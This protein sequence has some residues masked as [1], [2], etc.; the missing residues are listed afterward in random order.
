MTFPNPS[1]AL[2][3]AV[4]DELIRNGV[5]FAVGSPGSRSTALIVELDRRSE[6]RLVMQLDERSGSFRALGNSVATE[7]PSVVV[8]T[9]GSAVANLAP[10]IAEAER[11]GV[12]LIALTADRPKGAIERRSNQ[13]MDHFALFDELVRARASLGP[14][15]V[16]DDENA[17]WR[18][19]VAELVQAAKG[20]IQPPGPVHL[21]VAFEE[22]TVPVPDDGRSRSPI[23]PFTCEGA[24]ASQPWI[25]R[26]APPPSIGAGSIAANRAVVVAGR[27]DYDIEALLR[28]AGARG[29]P[30]L[31][32]AMSGGRGLDGALVGYAHWLIDGF[33][34]ALIP[35]TVVIAGQVNPGDRIHQ[36]TAGISTVFHVDRF[37]VFSDPGDNMSVGVTGDPV[38]FLGGFDSQAPDWMARYATFDAEVVSRVSG[39]IEQSPKMSGPAVANALNVPSWEALV[40]GSSLAIRDVEAHVTRVGWVHANRGLSG[41]DGFSSTVLGVAGARARTLALVGDLSFLH[42]SNAFLTEETPPAVF[43]VVDNGG[44]GLFDLLPQAAHIEHF[45]RL[46]ATPHRRDLGA[47]AA[48]HG[49]RYFDAPDMQRLIEAVDEGLERGD[50]SVI[51]VGVDRRTDVLVRSELDRL[52]AEVLIEVEI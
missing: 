4:V 41:I 31:A 16:D 27:G 22:P 47:L 32:T 17:S 2:A 44:G 12:P 13:T 48:F 25:T 46:F 52:V 29:I 34:S 38:E 9:S 28:S 1:T 30:V 24:P 35:D 15:T 3:F 42:D 36:S 5:Q 10:A 39:W 20:G 33:P 43:V 45:D 8:T 40:A 37:G 6:I 14:A 11:A 51:R 21:N 49:L 26:D 18:E 23:Y 19:T 50:T 7:M